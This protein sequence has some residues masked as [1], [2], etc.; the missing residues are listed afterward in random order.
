[1]FKRPQLCH[2]IVSKITQLN[3]KD[4][5]VIVDVVDPIGFEFAAGKFIS[6]NCGNE[7]FR[8]YSISSSPLIKNQVG[9]IAAVGHDGVGANYIRGL[10]IGDSVEFV[11]PSGR[12]V[13]PDILSENVTFVVTGTGIAPILSMLDYLESIKTTSKIKLYFGIRNKNELFKLEQLEQFKNTMQHFDY[14]LCFSQDVPEELSS[15]SVKGRVTENV[16]IDI[17]TQYFICGNPYMVEDMNNKLLANGVTNIFYEK[18]T[19]PRK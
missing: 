11:G 16:K 15:V 13:L 14:T 10:H 5:E 19:I 7:L 18:F 12:F 4:T 6:L 8:A 9:I 2:A 17:N 1:M 3:D